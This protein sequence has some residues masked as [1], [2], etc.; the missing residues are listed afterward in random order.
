MCDD[1]N[2][3]FLDMFEGVMVLLGIGCFMVGVILFIV[4]G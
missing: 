1:Y 3:E 4:G 2:G